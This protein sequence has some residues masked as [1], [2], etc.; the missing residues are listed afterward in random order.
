MIGNGLSAEEWAKGVA[1]REWGVM[2]P[3]DEL[4]AEQQTEADLLFKHGMLKRK[5]TVSEAVLP[6]QIAKRAKAA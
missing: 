3:D 5:I 6:Y 4:I 1:G 2:L